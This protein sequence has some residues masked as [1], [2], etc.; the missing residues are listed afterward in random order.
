MTTFKIA[1]DA[2]F[3]AN[4]AIPR[5]GGD[6]VLVPFEF[7]YRDRAE[8]AELFTGWQ[9]RSAKDQELFKARGAD[10][11]LVEVTEAQMSLEFDQVKDL[12]V[13]WGFDDPFEDEAIRALILTSVGAGKAIVD[14]YQAAFRAAREGN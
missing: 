8:L 9:E 13:G 12:V 11:T 1:Q 6:S 7:K 2:T 4:V 14:A 10:L 3:K 5:V